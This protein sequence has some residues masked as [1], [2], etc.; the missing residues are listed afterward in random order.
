MNKKVKNMNE[1]NR[2]IE[3]IDTKMKIINKELNQ[4]KKMNEILILNIQEIIE[5]THLT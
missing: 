5:R 3:N 4:I 1:I 2:Q